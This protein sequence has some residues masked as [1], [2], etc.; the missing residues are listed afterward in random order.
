MTMHSRARIEPELV[1]DEVI[2]A[3]SATPVLRISGPVGSPSGQPSTT[4]PTAE[5]AT[6][7]LTGPRQTLTAPIIV[8]GGRWSATVP[9]LSS[10]WGSPLVAPRSGAYLVSAENTLGTDSAADARL[11]PLPAPQLV[12]NVT[13]IS[14]SRHA[15][16]LEITFAAPLGD[17][18]RGP[19]RQAALADDYRTSRPEPLDAVFF[20]SFFG[21]NASCNPLA[22]DRE[23]AATRPGL[24]RY[25][26]VIDA[27]IPVPEGAIALIQGSAEWW[28]VRAAARLII[29]NEWLR[30]RYKRRAHQRVLQTWHGTPLKKLALDRPNHSLRTSAAVWR[31]RTRW[32]ALLSQ[33]ADSSR[34]FR[35]AYAFRG[36][37]W[38]IGY[39]RNDVLARTDA[40]AGRTTA[41]RSQLGLTP[42]LAV[43]LY[44]PTWRD[45]RPGEVDHLD[46]S[47]FAEQ[48]GS[49][50]VVLL[51][52]H[53]RSML[54][55]SE[56]TGSK[57]TGN[58]AAGARVIDVT[59]FP[60]VSDL[61]LAAD[62][63][64]TDY[65]SVMFDFTV[66]GK[67]VF[68]FTPDLADYRE[69]LRGFYF[70]LHELAPGPVVST[71]AALL[72]AV[73]SRD[74]LAPEYAARYAAW[75]AR[76]S[77]HDDGGASARVVARLIAEGMLD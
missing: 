38:E 17:H 7:T 59:D 36:P 14:F 67:P 28:R 39:P 46:V 6:L 37:L 1:I 10:A 15:N 50:Y 45:D 48:L 76:F 77:P 19:V 31:E 2:V 73:L 64:V 63:L 54:P 30:H 5:P 72:E 56:V 11:L 57:A 74:E 20:E 13:R 41:V 18:E 40:A 43:V 24:A 26:G 68:F 25:W 22:L 61:F 9:L 8:D 21:H 58:E 60:D 53:S 33:N 65:S 12:P 27:S 49:G 44:A 75:R 16:A 32:S 4:K 69:R 34:A 51:R 42:E 71:S 29:T 3:E 47:R 66:T 35:S 70:D 52:G 62:L 55:D 23:I